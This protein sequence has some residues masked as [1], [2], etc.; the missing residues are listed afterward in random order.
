VLTTP[1]M[2]RLLRRDSCVR[3]RRFFRVLR[4][5]NRFSRRRAYG[6]SGAVSGGEGDHVP[7][8]HLPRVQRGPAR[9]ADPGRRNRRLPAPGAQP[10][11]SHSPWIY[12]QATS[13][14]VAVRSGHKCHCYI[15]HLLIHLCY[16][17]HPKHKE[18]ELFAAHCMKMLDAPKIME[19]CNALSR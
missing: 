15:L 18:S 6:L 5:R 10:S 1:V 12:A 2:A 17:C 7:A 3:C 4:H 11:P 16:K 8:L 14:P 19:T 9:G 13:W